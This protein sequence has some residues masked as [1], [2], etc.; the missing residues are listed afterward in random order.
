MR[1]EE[2]AL[3]LGV[4]RSLVKAV[5][6]DFARSFNA[7]AGQRLFFL[8]KELYEQEI[9]AKKMAAIKAKKP[10]PVDDKTVKLAKYHSSRSQLLE[11]DAYKISLRLDKMKEQHAK[12]ELLSI[13]MTKLLANENADYKKVRKADDHDFLNYQLSKATAAMARNGAAAQLKLQIQMELK[14]GYAEVHKVLSEKLKT[15]NQKP[16]KT[17]DNS[18]KQPKIQKSNSK[19]RKAV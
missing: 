8:M 19:L 1:Q 10:E 11:N 15:A 2:I 17:V 3:Y 9:P 13:I 6:N 14:L 18:E 12:A 4:S 16:G 5:E 7:K